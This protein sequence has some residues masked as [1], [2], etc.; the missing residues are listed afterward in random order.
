MIAKWLRDS[1]NRGEEGKQ[2]RSKAKD[3]RTKVDKTL[4]GEEGAESN[5]A[6]D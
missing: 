3:G 1:I 4:Q 6:S 2:K 5:V